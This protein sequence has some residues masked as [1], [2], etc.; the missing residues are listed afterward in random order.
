MVLEGRTL[1]F[2]S[3]DGCYGSIDVIVVENGDF[4][5]YQ[6]VIY[7]K[8]PFQLIWSIDI[9]TLCIHVMYRIKFIA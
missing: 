4:D 7:G 2:Y 3:W 8:N 1:R 9:K 6:L 5:P